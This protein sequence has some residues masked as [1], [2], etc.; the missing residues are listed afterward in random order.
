MA[1]RIVIKNTLSK[2]MKEYFDRMGVGQNKGADLLGKKRMGLQLLN[3]VGNG[4]RNVT[5]VPPI[6]DG[7]LR[8][9]GSVFVGGE[10]IGDTKDFTG[11][12]MSTPNHS[13]SAPANVITIGYN[14]SYAAKQHEEHEGTYNPDGGLKDG[15]VSEKSGDVSGKFLEAHLLGDKEAIFAVYAET[16]RSVSA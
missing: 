14:T 9:S 7:I 10:F 6:L 13:H 3:F 11:N 2:G 15:P 1:S 5:A 8:G 4:S 16:L 12:P